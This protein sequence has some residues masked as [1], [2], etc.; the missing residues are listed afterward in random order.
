M[1]TTVWK[2]RIRSALAEIE[3]YI[4]EDIGSDEATEN[5]RKAY[6]AIVRLTNELENDLF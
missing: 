2:L 5:M 4:E 3:R 1:D 6:G